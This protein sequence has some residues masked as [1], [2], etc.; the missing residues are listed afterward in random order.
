MKNPTKKDLDIIEKLVQKEQKAADH[1][2]PEEKLRARLK[3]RLFQERKKRRFLLRYRK[4]VFVTA[5]IV[6]AAI[7]VFM[8]LIIGKQTAFLSFEKQIASFL[9]NSA[10][11]KT[12]A[13]W[14]E[15]LRHRTESTQISATVFLQHIRKTFE[16]AR[17]KALSENQDSLVLRKPQKPIFDTKR[18][19]EILFEEKAVHRF[20]HR[21]MLEKKEE[22]NG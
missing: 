10:G 5:G 2:L 18:R 12:L 16:E 22:K 20:L 14:E 3:Y 4:P 15:L 9:E 6:A 17:E 11:I 21:F 1:I 19:M 8:V 7:L 13:Q